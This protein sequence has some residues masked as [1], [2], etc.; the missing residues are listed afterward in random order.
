M[1]TLLDAFVQGALSERVPIGSIELTS[2]APQAR[3]ARRRRR[4][5]LR[6]RSVVRPEITQ[7]G[8][9][10]GWAV[11]LRGLEQDPSLDTE[12]IDVDGNLYTWWS[13]SIGPGEYE[14]AYR[15]LALDADEL[16][17]HRCS[18]EQLAAYDPFVAR[19]RL[20]DELRTL[21]DR[22]RGPLDPYRPSRGGP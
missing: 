4:W 16:L 12:F 8:R 10:R 1:R 9:L 18:D 5:A 6:R 2:S 19:Q 17:T 7:V 20:S 14:S 11:D 21:R 13:V 22:T 15:S 3:P